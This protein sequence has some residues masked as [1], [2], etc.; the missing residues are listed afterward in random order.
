MATTT[1]TPAE[2]QILLALAAES[3]HGYGIKLDIEART[4]GTMRLGSGTLYEAIQR[5]DKQGWL[6]VAQAPG[7]DP[8]ESRR[9][10]YRLTSD[11]RSLLERNLESWRGIVADAVALEVLPEI[12]PA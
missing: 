1:L 11:G 12:R 7:D 4:G 8:A 5:M 10:Y 9:K 2:L 3:R 6:E